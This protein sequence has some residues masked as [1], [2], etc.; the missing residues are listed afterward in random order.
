MKKI[1]TLFL[2]FIIS[3]LPMIASATVAREFYIPSVDVNAT[4]ND[5]GSID[6]VELISYDFDGDYNGIIR[7]INAIY[8]QN[9]YIK[10]VEIIDSSNNEIEVNEGYNGENNTYELSGGSETEIKIY[11]KSSNETKNVKIQY[12]LEN[13]MSKSDIEGNLYWNFYSVENVS[14]VDNARLSLRVNGESLD[15]SNSTYHVYSD[16]E[17]DTVY[18]DGIIDINITNLTST[19]A[20]DLDIPSEFISNMKNDTEGNNNDVYI[21]DLGNSEFNN[22]DNGNAGGAFIFILLILVGGFGIVFAGKQYQEVQAEIKL[23]RNTEQFVCDEFYHYPPSNL[24]P[25][26]INYIIRGGKVGMEMIPMSLFYLAEKGYYKIYTREKYI[27]WRG[28]V[29]DLVFSRNINSEEPTERHLKHLI[30]MFKAYET[31][32]EFSLLDMKDV[33]SKTAVVKIFRDDAN[34]WV[35]LVEEEANELNMTITIKNKKILTNYYNNEQEKWIKYKNYIEGA[36]ESQVSEDYLNDST[37]LLIHAN[38]LGVNS[39][40]LNKFNESLVALSKQCN[41]NN[42]NNEDTYY[43]QNYYN[44]Y[45]MYYPLY[46]NLYG[47]V[48]NSY[49]PPDSSG[50]SFDGGGFSGS[51]SGGDFGGGG[52]GGSDAF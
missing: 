15:E 16:G 12:R 11:T 2:I 47:D 40:K 3:C 20:V 37:M 43:D 27:K 41:K 18:N 46:N 1:I 30:E 23:Y 5:D 14:K 48:Q 17:I 22:R 21:D 35:K 26:L 34:E 49:A 31:D 28:Q 42:F 13:I 19:L 29:E 38:V 9:L 36:I 4:I 7:R 51:S 39:S 33:L 10:S 8:N 6:V 25:A 50:S 52:G 44:N 24:P 32:G 45:F